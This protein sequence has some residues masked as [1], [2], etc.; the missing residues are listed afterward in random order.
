[1]E[2]GPITKNKMLYFF[3]S[4]ITIEYLWDYCESRE[5]VLFTPI[6]RYSI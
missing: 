6:T 4:V 2:K 3:D 5:I 1:M